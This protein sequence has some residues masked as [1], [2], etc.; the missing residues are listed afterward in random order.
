ML[1]VIDHIAI[2]SKD[3]EKLAEWYVKNFKAEIIYCDS[4]WAFLQ[5]ENIKL[6]IVSP[7]QHPAHIAFSVDCFSEKDII[8]EHR[9]GSKSCYRKDPDG[10]IYELIKYEEKC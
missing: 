5:F 4:T 1:D 7:S 3:V 10:N 8:K 6:A 2:K 9:D